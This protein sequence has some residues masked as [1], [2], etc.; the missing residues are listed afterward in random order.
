MSVGLTCTHC[1]PFPRSFPKVPR[2]L[3]RDAVSPT[4][5]P[6]CCD[7]RRPTPHH[8]RE[9]PNAAHCVA[10]L[11]PRVVIPQATPLLLIHGFACG[12]DD[13]GT[14]P[15]IVATRSRREI[16]TFDNRGIGE[17]DAPSG[18]YRMDVLAEDAQRVLDDAKVPSACVLSISLAI[19]EPTRVRA[20]VLCCT[21]HGRKGAAAP[22]E[23]FLAMCQ[24]WA[25]QAHT[26][27]RI[28]WTSS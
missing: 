26:K 18:P 1:S 16:I 22:S 21:S 3:S 24:E 25:S 6:P 11:H 13:W 4:F 10:A 28:S 17:S 15:R 5:H 19:S 27:E 9:W 20:L 23:R 2:K 14:A 7:E 8:E 12:K